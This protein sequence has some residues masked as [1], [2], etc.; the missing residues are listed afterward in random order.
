M[1]QDRVEQELLFRRLKPVEAGYHRD[2]CCMD[3]TR[4]SLLTQIMTWVTN[5]V[6][7]THGPQSNTYWVYGLPGIGKTSLAHSICASLHDREQLAG[8]FFCRRDDPNLSEPRH[9]LPT[10]INKLAGNFPL[11]RSRVSERL[12][13]DAN[14]TPES[15][16]DSLLLDLISSLPR[17]PQQPLAFVIDA[18][19]ECGSPQSRSGILKI[20][21]GA[22]AQAPWLKIIIT[23]RPEVDILRFFDAPTQSSHIR[24]DLARDQDASADLQTFARSQFDLVALSWCLPTP[25]PEE[26]LFNRVISRANGLFIFI[27]T[28]VLTLET[29]ADPTELLEATVHDPAGPGLKSLYE[30]YS[31]VLKARIVHSNSEFQRMIS[32]LLTTAPYRPLCEET[33]AQLAIMRPNLVKKWINDLSPLLYRD[34]GANGGIRIRHL[35]ISDFFISSHCEY[36]VDLQDANVQLGIA[37]LNIMVEQLRFNICNLE[38]SRIPNADIE[39][40]P[41]RIAQNISDVLW[42]SSLHWSNHLC[43]TPDNGDERVWG[44]LKEFFEGLYPLFWI[45]VLSITGMIS[46]GA[47]SI[48]KV[49]SW[50]NVSIAL[51]CCLFAY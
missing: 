46:I 20:L 40:L 48:R 25:W 34:E 45:E 5:N 41:S 12:H 51:T 29:C 39:D 28:V 18:F 47:P 43:F 35:S 13:K 16:K 2:F 11:F 42:Y 33:I 21:T 26:S 3:G 49:I 37:C 38:D 15:M 27:K 36:Q 24:Y 19:D 7:P 6:G 44:S 22:A 9:I 30:L 31:S 8:A 4:Q 50:V 32:V 23:S 10:L 17:P 14:L 1:E